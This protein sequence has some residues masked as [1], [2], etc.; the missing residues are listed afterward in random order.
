MK[1]KEEKKNR[2]KLHR[3]SVVDP[4]VN[5]RVALK[6]VKFASTKVFENLNF[7]SKQV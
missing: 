5:V 1:K 2:K 6:K 7:K 4:D 3:T